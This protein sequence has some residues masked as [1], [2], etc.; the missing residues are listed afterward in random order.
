MVPTDYN[1][2]FHP[3]VIQWMA[4]CGLKEP[5]IAKELGLAD[6]QFAEWSGRYPEVAAAVSSGRV[7]WEQVTEDSLHKLIRGYEYAVTDTSVSRCQK[8]GHTQKQNARKITKHVPPNAHAV[9]FAMRN[10]VTFKLAK[11][12]E[13]NFPAGFPIDLDSLDLDF[14]NKKDVT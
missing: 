6:A 14:N 7:Y 2:T 5:E 12:I 9:T 13:A 1:P 4:R 8:C 10:R 11:Q 3:L